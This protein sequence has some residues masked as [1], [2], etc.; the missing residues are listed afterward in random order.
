MKATDKKNHINSLLSLQPLVSELKKMVAED[1][2]GARKL[3]DS[4]IK[5]VQAIPELL[6][7]VQDISVLHQHSEIVEAL[8]STIFPPSTSANQGIYAISYPFHSETVFASPKFKELFLKDGSDEIIIPHKETNISIARASLS[9]AYNIILKKFYSFSAP[10]T[11]SSIHPF[12]DEETGMVKY[13]ELNLNAQFVNARLIDK[14]FSLPVNFSPQRMLD[15]DELK[16]VFPLEHFQFEGVVVVDVVDVTSEQII[17]EIKD[18]LLNINASSDVTVYADLQPHVQTLIG[19]KD[20]EVGITPFFTMNDIYLYAESYHTNSLLFRHQDAAANRQ[21][22]ISF[23]QQ[24]FKTNDQPLLFQSLNETNSS[25]NELVKYYFEQGAKSLIICPLKCDDGDL[26][27]L[28]EITSSDAA[29]LKFQH[30]AKLQSATQLFSLALEKTNENL[31]LQI[32]KTIKE[33]FTAIQ[34]AVEWKF[35]EAAFNYLQ[36]RQVHDA[37]KMPSITFE[38]VYPLYG[39]IDVRNSSVERNNAIQLDLLEQLTMA[40]DVLEKTSRIHHFPLLK[41]VKYKI[42]KY[43]ASTSDN[44]LSDDELQIYDFLQLDIDSLFKHLKL[45]KPELNKIVEEYFSK[46]DPQRNIL[47]QHR[48]E[49]EESITRINDVLDRFIDQEQK[50]VQHIFPHY[51]ER[52]I[53][54]GIEFNIYVGQSLAPYYKFDDIYVKNL[55]L[56]QITMLAKA[57]RLT[58][59]LEK[60]LSLPLQTTQLILAHSIPLSISFRRKERKFDVDGA[61]NIRYEIIKKRIDKVHLKDSEER[62]TQPG[63][64]A[65]VYSQQK[66]LAEYLEYIEYLQ[67]EHLLTDNVEHVELEDTQGISGLKAVRVEVNLTNEN[68]TPKVELSKITA[69]QL[70]RK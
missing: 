67:S 35:T 44:L 62:L 59:A 13:L 30:L 52:Y 5:E 32:D 17:A 2:P 11:A 68:G 20:I 51:F 70:L 22:I 25:Q 39:A 38:N 41:E 26:I 64:V 55:K 18:A 60:R 16:E 53:T 7:P 9:L 46:L 29:K 15:V 42:D 63:K 57:A 36:N 66:E 65:V 31:E 50:S 4:L 47:Y 69:Q 43:I 49:Y 54:D 6:E 28:L 40:R 37:A 3:Y 34:P 10:V 45:V 56:W 8:L 21:R 23:C 19:L 14:D 61:Y 48:K 33:H 24:I 58:N 1:K 27:G 12:T